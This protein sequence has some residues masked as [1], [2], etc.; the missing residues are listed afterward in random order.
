M[1]MDIHQ[2]GDQVFTRN[3]HHIPVAVDL[4]N[5]RNFPVT[6]LDVRFDEAKTAVQNS[7]VFKNH[8]QSSF[9]F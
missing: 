3:I 7:A 4:A 9:P 2:A 6:N 8:A 1:G 5:V